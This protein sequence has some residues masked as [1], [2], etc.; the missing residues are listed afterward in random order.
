VLVHLGTQHCFVVHGMDGLDEITLTDRTRVSEGKAGIVSS[1]FVEPGD[2]G[3]QR[4]K[5]KD[6]AGGTAEENAQIARDILK[7]RKGPK[8]DVVCLNAAPAFVAG[9][10]ARTMQEGFELANKAID[11]GSAMGKLEKLV[12]FTNRKHAA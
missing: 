10:K 11:S 2:F 12:A 3:L 8:R 6:L 9:K 7:G 1:Y 4:V 5:I